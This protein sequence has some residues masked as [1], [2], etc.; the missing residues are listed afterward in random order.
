LHHY[1]DGDKKWRKSPLGTTH[2]K[3]ILNEINITSKPC[4]L[5]NTR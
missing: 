3:F 5:H 1:S 2:N 4:T